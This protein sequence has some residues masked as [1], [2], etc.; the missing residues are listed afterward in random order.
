MS[1]KGSRAFCTPAT[2]IGSPA[3]DPSGSLSSEVPAHGVY[4]GPPPTSRHASDDS[5]PSTSAR[6][7][8]PV[9]GL[10]SQT[11]RRRRPSNVSRQRARMPI[12]VESVGARKTNDVSSISDAMHVPSISISCEAFAA[13]TLHEPH[14]ATSHVSC[15]AS[16][17]PFSS[18]TGAKEMYSP[19]GRCTA[20]SATSSRTPGSTTTPRS[21]PVVVRVR[22]ASAGSSHALHCTHHHREGN[23]APPQFF[24]A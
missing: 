15:A 11:L 22:P 5:A 8:S 23:P 16:N 4:H 24:S 20:A 10:S 21:P 13:R 17:P 1:M 18:L 12:S 19:D 9:I 2:S 3:T 7:L 14:G 6:D